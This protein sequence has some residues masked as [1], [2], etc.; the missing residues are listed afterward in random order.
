[1]QYIE[2]ICPV[3]GK[4]FTVAEDVSADRRFCTL[5][6]Y[7]QSERQAYCCNR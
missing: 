7:M 5:E 4:H 6:C 1:M 2:R 3:C